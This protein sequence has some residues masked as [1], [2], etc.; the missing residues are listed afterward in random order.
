MLTIRDRPRVRRPPRGAQRHPRSSTGQR[1]HRRGR[2]GRERVP[3]PCC[4][5][6]RAGAGGPPRAAARR[7]VQSGG[8]L[9]EV[10]HAREVDAVPAAGRRLP[11]RHHFYRRRGS[12]SVRRRTCG[13]SCGSRPSGP[14]GSSSTPGRPAS[15]SRR[16][17]PAAQ[18]P[19]TTAPAHTSVGAT[20]IR[21]FL[22]PVTYQN[23]PDALLPEPLRESTRWACR[24]GSG[25]PGD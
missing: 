17:A 12:T 5:P 19:A 22:R 1:Q 4:A 25:R 15:R 9:G 6:L 3:R 23:A 16:P 8:G 7:G 20:A 11:D 21:R 13:R 14:A 2:P 24:A 18:Y 10:R